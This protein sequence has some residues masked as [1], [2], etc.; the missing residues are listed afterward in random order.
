[1]AAIVRMLGVLALV[2]LVWFGVSLVS[3][4]SRWSRWCPAPVSRGNNSR[5]ISPFQLLMS[6]C[7]SKTSP[8]GATPSPSSTLPSLP[9]ARRLLAGCIKSYGLEHQNAR[10]VRVAPFPGKR[11]FS[12]RGPPSRKEGT[13]APEE[14]KLR[15][16]QVYRKKKI[17][18]HQVYQ[19]GWW[20]PATH[21]TCKTCKRNQ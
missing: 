8:F 11:P 12:E 10:N 18:N 5:L 21:Q 20:G 17:E 2:R 13:G 14:K 9:P 1:M 19:I 16:Q 7:C 3:R 6:L 4:C 15:I